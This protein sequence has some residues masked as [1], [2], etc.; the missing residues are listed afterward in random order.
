MTNEEIQAIALANG[1][2]L[3]KQADST[4]G[5]NPY[6]YRFARALL[7]DIEMVKAERAV[8][9]RKWYEAEEINQKLMEELG[10]L[11]TR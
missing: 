1:F 4:M 5:L 3:K 11:K 9:I 7:A 8:W 2:E 10:Y 6:V